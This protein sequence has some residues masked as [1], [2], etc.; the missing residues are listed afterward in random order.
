MEL[1]HTLLSR[2]CSTTS[3]NSPLHGISLQ[4]ICGS[5]TSR[6]FSLESESRSARSSRGEARCVVKSRLRAAVI[7][8]RSYRASGRLKPLSRPFHQILGVPAAATPAI[9]SI[10]RVPGLSWQCPMEVLSLSMISTRDV[11]GSWCSVT[12]IASTAHNSLHRTFS[13]RKFKIRSS[14]KQETAEREPTTMATKLVISR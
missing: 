5:S 4:R 10:S 1:P 14:G 6:P 12:I 13:L 7:R 3:E 2:G 9:H 8:G 11:R